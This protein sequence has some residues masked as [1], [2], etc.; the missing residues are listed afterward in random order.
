MCR[1]RAPLPRAIRVGF[2]HRR[3]GVCKIGERGITDRAQRC[4]RAARGLQAVDR[5]SCRAGARSRPSLAER[6]RSTPS[7]WV[8]LADTDG[9]TSL[10][11]SHPWRAYPEAMGL[12]S[13][14]IGLFAAPRSA[15][16]SA[17]PRRAERRRAARARHRAAGTPLWTDYDRQVRTKQQAVPEGWATGHV[18]YITVLEDDEKPDPQGDFDPAHGT[19]VIADDHMES[20]TERSGVAQPVR[21]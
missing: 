7:L 21:R 17:L 2:D 9:P 18:R 13:W 4:H 15:R 3:P 12:R 14:L 16:P 10:C 11:T 8:T 5:R 19:G 1:V 6:R 20:T